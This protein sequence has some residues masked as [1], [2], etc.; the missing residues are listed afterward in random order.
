MEL[1]SIAR[2]AARTHRK[3]NQILKRPPDRQAED[4]VFPR[5][6]NFQ[7]I[8]PNHWK[9]GGQIFQCLENGA[10]RGALGD[11]RPTPKFQCLELWGSILPIV[12]PLRQSQGGQA[13]YRCLEHIR[14]YPCPSVV[15]NLPFEILRT[16]NKKAPP[17][18]GCS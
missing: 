1:T 9:N 3:L 12:G 15:K 11:A 8:S 18:R 7:E 10:E 2:T 6:G 17:R 4:S 14:V 5:F 13:H 16:G